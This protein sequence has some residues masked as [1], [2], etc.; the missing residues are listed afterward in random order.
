MGL[1]QPSLIAWFMFYENTL[2]YRMENILL[3]QASRQNT[4][5]P[6]KQPHS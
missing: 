4:L 2:T 3:A 6:E 1:T 5:M